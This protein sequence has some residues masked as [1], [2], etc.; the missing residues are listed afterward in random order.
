MMITFDETQH[1]RAGGGQFTEKTNT[2]P[3]GALTLERD[4]TSEAPVDIDSELAELY[5]ARAKAQYEIDG[6]EVQ[7]ERYRKYIEKERRF[8]GR[9]QDYEQTIERYEGMVTE[10]QKII[11]DVTV[12]EEPLDAEFRRRGGWPRA[13]LVSGGHLHSSM[14]CSTCNREGKL[15]R[16]AW[17]TDYSGATEDE[18]VE[19]A[20]S[21][22]CTT[23]FPSAPVDILNR[24]S[25]LLTPD[26]KQQAEER[27]LREAER[28][29][30]AIEKEQKAI[31]N[32]DGT[33]LRLGYRE[34][35]SLVTANRELV[36]ALTDIEID[37]ARPFGNQNYAA[38]RQDWSDML[39]AAIAH[40]R[41]ITAE[42]VLAEAG[43]KATKKAASILR[44]WG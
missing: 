34:A 18:I 7:I 23:C 22:A 38:E 11:D 25:T 30:K 28:A 21:R 29:R 9:M 36:D 3:A 14:H 26:E 43:A 31:A 42:D 24:P 15:T 10:A 37:R 33:P 16:F 2:A 40:K 4:L 32:P 17:M 27:A 5:Y 35:R 39:V 19:A 44:S 12:Q 41:G 13:F 1:P 20:A 8:P 6:Y